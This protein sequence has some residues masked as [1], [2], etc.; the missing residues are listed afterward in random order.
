MVRLDKEWEKHKAS[1]KKKV[2]KKKA[3]KKKAVEKKKVIE[4]PIREVKKPD[5]DG[6]DK[7]ISD[8][9]G[10]SVVEKLKA[11]DK[12]VEKYNITKSDA[13][14]ILTDKEKVALEKLPKQETEEEP[15]G[16]ELSIED[17]NKRLEEIAPLS[18]VEKEKAITVLAEQSKQTKKALREQLK[19]LEDDFKKKEAE[20]E[21]AKTGV[22]RVIRANRKS[23][24]PDSVC[25]EDF[26][27]IK[28]S[29]TGKE[30]V[31]GVNIDKVAKY[32]E[33]KFE[34][35]TIYGMREETIEVYQE[36]IWTPKGKGIIKAAVEDL[37]KIYSRNNIVAE[38]L[39]KVKRR[40]ET[41]REEAED[42][43]LHKRAVAN[44]VLDLEDINDIK[45][46]PHSKE[47][48]FRHKW[49]MYYN[50]SAQCPNFINFV[51][52]TFYEEDIDTFQEWLGLHLVMLYLFKKFAIFY[53]PKDTGKSVVLN[54]LSI[55]MNHNISG[56]SIQEI[57]RAKAFDLLDLK[58]KDANICDD[59]SSRDMNA[60]GG[61]KMSVG[62][63]FIMGEQKFGDK[64]KF[65]NTAKGNYACNK[66]PSP[67]EDIDDE[68]YYDRILPFA[69][70]NVTP[71]EQQDKH[72]IDKITTPEELSGVLNWA[73][74]GYKRLR[75]Q[76][77][78]SNERTPEE[79]KSLMIQN[80]NSLSEFTSEVL[81]K[82]EGEKIGK[83]EMYQIYC[84][85]CENHKPQLSPDSKD[86][87]GK[88]LTRFAPY[89]HASSNGKER[90]WLNVK[91]ND[92]YYGFKKTMSIYSKSDKNSKNKCFY[93]DIYNNSKP[94]IPVINSPSSNEQ[95][96]Q[97]KTLP[98]V[99][100][101]ELTKENY[102]KWKREK[103]KTNS[104]SMEEA[105]E[106][107]GEEVG[108]FDRQLQFFEDPI[109]D[110][111]KPLD[112]KHCPKCN[113]P[114]VEDKCIGGCE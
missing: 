97:P 67:K 52:H 4:K 23:E 77:K 85:W 26:L 45:F 59:L 87:L 98:R 29:K 44:G 5:Y 101:L 10:A 20:Q 55:F 48:N 71:K 109:C 69:L 107:F 36:G 81:E 90:Y 37:L 12:G 86:K 111:I 72:L 114:M 19:P 73:I 68:A 35:R 25:L 1:G 99:A 80:G 2:V 62:D 106:L 75:K 7:F 43:P 3:V 40:T 30:V 84:M 92:T 28:I 66:M 88:N 76:N 16:E 39:E 112:I 50:P 70:E 108:Q 47:F 61:I 21:R 54:F 15:V 79:I 18:P 8:Y 104:F 38:I 113:A 57:S 51:N 91:I 89:C 74:E 105:K 102:I 63:G 65:R 33:N 14:A 46:I 22:K 49:S 41:S 64:T 93:D 42:T 103:L 34:M 11:V 17:I 83:D 53:G 95:T 58:N 6:F 31:T 100:K 27:H 24:N 60:T 9:I 56:L 32:I 94:V 82:A 78:F 110:G 96:E 13:N